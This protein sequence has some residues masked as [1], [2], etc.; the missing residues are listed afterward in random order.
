M[1]GSWTQYQVEQGRNP[2]PDIGGDQELWAQ[3]E[4]SMLQSDGLLEGSLEMI[5]QTGYTSVNIQCFP[6]DFS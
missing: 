2:G 3:G 5:R 6:Y 1:W 4:V